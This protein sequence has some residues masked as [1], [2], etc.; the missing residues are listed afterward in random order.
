MGTLA[1]VTL[2]GEP[3]SGLSTAIQERS[4]FPHTIVL[5]SSNG[6]GIGYVGLPGNKIKGGYEM[7]DV[8]HGADEAGG[9]LVDSA[10]RLLKEHAGAPKP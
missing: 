7:S 8:G 3:L 9:F 10:V 2:P 1:I 5:G 4:P 6:R